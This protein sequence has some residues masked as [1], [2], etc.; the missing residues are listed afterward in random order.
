MALDKVHLRK[1]LKLFLMKDS[2]RSTAI[3]NDAREVMKR[4]EE[5][6][7]KGGDF[8]VPFWRDAKVHASGGRDLVE[9]T[10]EQVE[11]IGGEGTSILDCGMDFFFGGPRN[12]VGSMRTSL[13]FLRQ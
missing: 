5:G 4:V 10:A 1:L 12:G 9:A 3:R 6:R 7:G 2:V 11:K 13:S 8:H